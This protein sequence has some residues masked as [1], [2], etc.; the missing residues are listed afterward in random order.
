MDFGIKTLSQLR[1]NKT[2]SVIS[3]TSGAVPSPV[4]KSVNHRNV[5]SVRNG[6]ERF[7]AFGVCTLRIG[8]RNFIEN[9]IYWFARSLQIIFE[10][11]IS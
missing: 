9:V 3:T 4:G 1:E 8:S 2:T 5:V 10:L 7:I 6:E 11:K